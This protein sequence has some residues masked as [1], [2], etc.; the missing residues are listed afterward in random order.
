MEKID[1]SIINSLL[2]PDCLDKG[3]HIEIW[4]VIL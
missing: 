2:K 1:T 3:Q 4:D